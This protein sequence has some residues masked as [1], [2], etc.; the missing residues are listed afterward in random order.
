MGHYLDNIQNRPKSPECPHCAPNENYARELMQLFSLG[1]SRLAPDGTPLR[2]ARGRLIE[3]YTQRDVEEL[4]RALTGWGA[5]PDPPQRPSRNWLNWGKPLSPT[6]SPAER[7][8]G[9]KQV[10][11]KVFPAGQSHEK[12]LRDAVE[13]LMSHENIA[14]FVALRMIQHLVKS[15]PT[16]AYV[17]R[18]ASAFRDNGRGVAGDMKA[19]VKA[20]LLDTEARAGDNPSTARA[21]DGKF[22]EPFQFYV[23]MYRGFG[24]KK[25]PGKSWGGAAISGVQTPFDQESVFGFYAPTDRAPGS[26]LLAPEQRLFTGIDFK[27]RLGLNL[28]PST[29]ND[30]AQRIEY[31]GYDG[32]QCDLDTLADAFH[33][34]PRA[35]T[36]LLS[37]R[38]FRGVMP[39]PLR[40]NVEQMMRT[41]SPPWTVTDR[42]HGPVMLT[43][44]VL[45]APSFGAVR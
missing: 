1:V 9:A 33:Q 13:L 28:W 21:D 45:M 42:Y 43:A 7:D 12:D 38:Y 2:D 16:P 34:S 6:G 20:V 26:Q 31:P 25:I 39:P 17:R 8:T 41:P 11:G 36:D 29:W 44:I 37:K 14:P 5:N 15:N 35:F 32:R 18:V 27:E 10:L 19:V 40:L 22:R 23:A 3:T 24:C 30:S 4:A